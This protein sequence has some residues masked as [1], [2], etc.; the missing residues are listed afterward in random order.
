MIADAPLNTALAA[1]FKEL[2]LPQDATDWL[3][4]LWNIIQ[5]L[6]DCQDGDFNVGNP[7]PAHEI[8]IAHGGNSFYLMHSQQLLP[9]LSIALN[10][11]YAA[12]AAE[13]SGKADAKSYM[14]RAGYYDIVLLVFTLVHGALGARN[15][16]FDIMSMYGESLEAYLLEFNGGA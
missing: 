3:L 9:A 1:K 12:N 16:A 6:D 4:N 7:L 5:F 14:W 13:N 15:N 11:W 2:Q 8:L 10:K